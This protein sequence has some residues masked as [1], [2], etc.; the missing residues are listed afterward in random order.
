M[1]NKSRPEKN[2]LMITIETWMQ[3]LERRMN[4]ILRPILYCLAIRKV[5]LLV[6][7]VLS[8]T[9]QPRCR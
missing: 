9:L 2:M 7:P 3:M 5:N 1:T 8:N 6:F 4:T